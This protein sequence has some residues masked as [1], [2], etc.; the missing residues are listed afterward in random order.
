VGT[1]RVGRR[2]V[3]VLLWTTWCAVALA[4]AQEGAPEVRRAD[5]LQSFINPDAY[6]YQFYERAP[7]GHGFSEGDSPQAADS[8]ERIVDFLARYLK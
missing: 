7:G 6:E 3:S 8:L 5:A 2:V 4:R 1:R